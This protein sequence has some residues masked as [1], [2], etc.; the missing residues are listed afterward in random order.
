M[1]TFLLPSPVPSLSQKN[2]T[3]PCS[4]SLLLPQ[5]INPTN[6][7]SD[8]GLAE[9][10]EPFSQLP[11]HVDLSVLGVTLVLLSVVASTAL[12]AFIWSL[13]YWHLGRTKDLLGLYCVSLVCNWPK[14][15]WFGKWWD[16]TDCKKAMCIILLR[17]WAGKM[18]LL[19]C[20]YFGSF[21][22]LPLCSVFVSKRNAKD[23]LNVH[24]GLALSVLFLL[25]LVTAI[26]FLSPFAYAAASPKLLLVE[27]L[28]GLFVF[29]AAS[30]WN[31]RKT[32]SK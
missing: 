22:V 6:G 16:N 30:H 32:P 17:N 4:W 2:E 13:L 27:V 5:I 31:H 26:T 24:C 20:L 8:S 7:N 9:L 3:F 15:L 14:S 29:N 28:V 19:H 18:L 21:S 1:K 12:L 11:F 23:N 25:L 10:Q